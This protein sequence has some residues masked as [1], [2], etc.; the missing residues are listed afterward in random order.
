MRLLHVANNQQVKRIL[1]PG[2]E[3]CGPG[4]ELYLHL[5][6]TCPLFYTRWAKEADDAHFELTCGIPQSGSRA[7]LLRAFKNG[8]NS[9]E[10]FVTPVTPKV[11]KSSLDTVL[12]VRDS[13]ESDSS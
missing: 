8:N 9:R 4:A 7:D 5:A 10:R 12:Y 1:L 13:S 11:F 6:N 2:K 3:V